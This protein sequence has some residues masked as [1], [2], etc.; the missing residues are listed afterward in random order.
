VADHQ[1]RQLLWFTVVNVSYSRLTKMGYK[2]VAFPA[3]PL[4]LALD[5]PF[6]GIYDNRVPR[7]FSPLAFTVRQQSREVS[8]MKSATALRL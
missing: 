5:L 8:D 6:L 3:S 4:I 7:T 1:T 2:A